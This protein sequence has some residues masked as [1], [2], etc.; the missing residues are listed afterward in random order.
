MTGK[1]LLIEGMHGLGDNIYQ[2]AVLKA[3]HPARD[4]YLV[5]SW[6]QLYA[7]LQHVQCVK[8]P[9]VRLRTQSRNADEQPVRAWR[10]PPAG[11]ERYRWHYVSHG[12]TILES[13]CDELGIR[14]PTL[15]MDGPAAGP[16]PIAEPYVVIRPATIR[17]EWR[18]DSRNPRP[19]Y[20]AEAAAAA[21][22]AGYKVVSVAD[23]KAEEEWPLDPLPRA[24]VTYHGGE[25]RLG[26][27]LSLVAGSSA[28]IGGVGWLVPAALAYRVPMLLIYGGWGTHNGPGRIF[29]P[30][31]DAS[32]VT[33]LMPDNFCMCAT[34]SHECNKTISDVG[35]KID[36][37]FAR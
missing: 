29:D 7:D 8:H 37:F 25:L 9:N 5:T 28:V 31:V 12:G 16:A 26:A 34:S 15:D 11:A 3:Y 19:E 21:R 27:L 14:P 23:L 17:T 6:P 13:L 36:R 35:A 22:R 2:R 33:Q 30:R 1:P 10:M 18:A 32:R 4:I 20:L 24:D